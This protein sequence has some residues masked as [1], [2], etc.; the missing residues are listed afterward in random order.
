MKTNVVV[1][2]KGYTQ[3]QLH[4]AFE[5]LTD[6]MENWKMPIRTKIHISDWN[7]MCEACIYMTGSELWQIYDLGE[8]IMEV[9][10]DGYYNTIGA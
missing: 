6:G 3:K 5:K 7:I 2:S 9:A 8:G 10:A 1:S 4:S